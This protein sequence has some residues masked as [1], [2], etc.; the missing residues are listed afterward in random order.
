MQLLGPHTIHQDEKY[1]L[2]H[3]GCPASGRLGTLHAL[4]LSTLEWTRKADA[5]GPGRGG[6]VLA[7]LADGSGRLLRFG[8]FAGH[9]TDDMAVYSLENEAWTSVTPTVEDNRPA[10]EARSVHSLVGVS[11]KVTQNGKKV[12]AMMCVGEREPTAKEVGHD[13]AGFVSLGQRARARRSTEQLT[14]SSSRT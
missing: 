5:P 9:E 3:A 7:R 1:V 6:T 13:G 11:G 14:R 2:V 8:G 12:V 4:D 10:P